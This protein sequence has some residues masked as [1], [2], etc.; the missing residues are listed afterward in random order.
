MSDAS[1]S[2]HHNHLISENPRE[3]ASWYAEKLGGRIAGGEKAL[4]APSIVV[5][6]KGMILIVRGQNKGETISAK[7]SLEWGIDHFGFQVE[8]DFDGYCNK[9]KENGVK[10]TRDPMDIN[11]TMRIA[12]IEGPDGVSIELVHNRR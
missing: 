4:E 7:D 10:F 8:G 1:I 2:F 6:F 12:F 3:C 9:L 11:P 5:T